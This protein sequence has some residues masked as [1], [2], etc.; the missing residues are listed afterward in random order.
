M[1]YAERLAEGK[2]QGNPDATGPQESGKPG[3]LNRCDMAGDHLLQ[4]EIDQI[5]LLADQLESGVYESVALRSDQ[6]IIGKDDLL[7][8]LQVAHWRAGQLRPEVHR[9]ACEALAIEECPRPSPG[10]H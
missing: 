1:T 3:R 10:R 9:R 4:D 6:A 7:H 8:L 5:R 2:R